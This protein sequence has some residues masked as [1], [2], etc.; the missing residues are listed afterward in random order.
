MVKKFLI[1]SIISFSLTGCSF[2]I[3]RDDYKI[4]QKTDSNIQTEEKE[5][6][7]L[8]ISKRPIT[9]AEPDGGVYK[10]PFML[11]LKNNKANAKIFYTTDMKNFNIDTYNLY[12]LPIV[13]EKDTKIRFYS[14]LDDYYEN[15]KEKT[16][17]IKT[18]NLENLSENTLNESAMYE[19]I[20][21]Y[22]INPENGILKNSFE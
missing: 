7:F 6:V 10:E 18:T 12:E 21:D 20:Y 8:E 17:Y 13:I 2:K 19:F 4:G 9:V 14:K 22:K 16:Y 1:I 15:I 3:F 11:T 5:T